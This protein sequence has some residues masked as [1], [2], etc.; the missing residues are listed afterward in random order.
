MPLK[1]KEVE[2]EALQLPSHERAKLAEHLIHSLD[3]EEDPEA[4]KLWIKEAERRYRQYKEG[5]VKTK[6]ASLVFKEARSKLSRNILKNLHMQLT[7]V[8]KRCI[9]YRYGRLPENYN[10]L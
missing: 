5:K 7:P 3:E 2:E 1:V 10:L 4:E 9:I 6:P 8:T